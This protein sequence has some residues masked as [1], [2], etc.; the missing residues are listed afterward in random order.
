MHQDLHV[1]MPQFGYSFFFNSTCIT[2]VLSHAPRKH[3]LLSPKHKYAIGSRIQFL[4]YCMAR[5]CILSCS[6]Y[7]F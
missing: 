4:L 7:V 1:V 3:F 5:I 2:I 6:S